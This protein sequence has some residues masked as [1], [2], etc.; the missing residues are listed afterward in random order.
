MAPLCRMPPYWIAS[1][2]QVSFT[3]LP[4]PLMTLLTTL[5]NTFDKWS[6]AEAVWLARAMAWRRIT[7]RDN[8][9]L[10][11]N[12]IVNELKVC[13]YQVKSQQDCFVLVNEAHGIKLFCR[14]FSSD[15]HVLWQ[16]YLRHELTPLIDLV[17]A[18]Q[19][20]VSTVFD[21]GSNIGL[22]A[23][24]LSH[25]F[26]Q[27]RIYAVEPAPDNF[28]LLKMNVAANPIPAVLLNTGVWHK[29]A[30]L[31]FDRSFRDGQDWSIALTE[32]P[33]GN[34]AEYVDA[35][36]INDIVAQHGVTT[37]DLLKIDIEGGE[38]YI[39]NEAREGLEFLA[40]TCVIAIEVHDEFQIEDR[41]KAILHEG[42]F[43]ISHSGEYLVGVREGAQPSPNSLPA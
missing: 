18:R 37:I 24:R 26:P 28:R 19:L 35:L 30:R 1:S 20:P 4:L 33:T 15:L 9:I 34:P 39:F 3:A 27:A 36:S 5:R 42:G 13:G 6:L 41:I 29:A 16:L 11:E 23:I 38:R 14:K 31:Y 7:G 17:N 10:E 2:L 25:A 43:S 32:V 40:I 8:K 22:A 21:I 12:K